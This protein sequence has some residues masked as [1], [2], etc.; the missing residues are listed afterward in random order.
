MEPPFVTVPAAAKLLGVTYRAAQLHVERLQQQGILKP[1]DARHYGKVY[2]AGEILR[3]LNAD[4]KDV[5]RRDQRSIP[6]S[7]HKRA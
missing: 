7:D 5:E 6:T 4:I 2:E 1:R 3:I